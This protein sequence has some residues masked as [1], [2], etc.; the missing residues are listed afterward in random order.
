M[1]TAW[2]PSARASSASPYSARSARPQ[3]RSHQRKIIT[4]FAS[5]DTYESTSPCIHRRARRTDILRRVERWK[6]AC[7]AGFRTGRPAWRPGK[8]GQEQSARM[9]GSLTVDDISTGGERELRCTTDPCWPWATRPPNT[10]SSRRQVVRDHRGAWNC[11]PIPICRAA[12]RAAPYA[13]AARSQVHREA[14][15]R[16]ISSKAQDRQRHCRPQH[17]GNRSPSSTIRA[18]RR[19]TGPIDFASTAKTKRHGHVTG[20]GLRNQARKAV[21]D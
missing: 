8:A 12:V 11:S 9:A 14:T 20:P 16:R 4:A 5:S 21:F 17:A 13:A 15:S 1:F 7:S 10:V 2:T 6:P 19:V 18:A 3:V